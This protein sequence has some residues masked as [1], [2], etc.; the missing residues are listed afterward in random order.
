MFHTLGLTLL[1]IKDYVSLVNSLLRVGSGIT[2]EETEVLQNQVT[3]PRKR[4]N[5][6]VF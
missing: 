5:Q 2:D 3:V 6:I 4:Q 1:G